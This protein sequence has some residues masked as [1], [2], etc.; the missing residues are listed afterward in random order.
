MPVAATIARPVQ[1]VLSPGGSVSVSVTTRST[2]AAGSGGRPG[3]L[4][5]SGLPGC[6]LLQHRIG[7]R[8]DQIR[9]DVDTVEIAQMADDLALMPRAYIEMI[10]SSNPGKR[11]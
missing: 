9:R 8:A 7:N 1:W 2:S 6:D 11:R 5:L 10:L 3:F 4:I